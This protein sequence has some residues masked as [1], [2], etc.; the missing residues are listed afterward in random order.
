MQYHTVE[1]SGA[2]LL[3]EVVDSNLLRVTMGPQ[4][5]IIYC[6]GSSKSSF[7]LYT[8]N[9]YMKNGLNFGFLGEPIEYSIKGTCLGTFSQNF[10]G[11]A[12]PDY[13]NRAIKHVDI[14]ITYGRQGVFYSF[15]GLASLNKNQCVH[16]RSHPAGDWNFDISFNLD[17][18]NMLLLY[19]LPPS[20]TVA[21]S[22]R[23]KMQ[24]L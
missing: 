9:D 14:V 16:P 4:G 21:N 18:S 3:N 8:F 15:K 22:Y 2:V 6:M 12:E 19:G 1:V 5:L 17:V 24:E 7:N 23:E 11:G 10:G 13:Y 20:S